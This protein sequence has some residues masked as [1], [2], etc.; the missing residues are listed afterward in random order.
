MSVE[1]RRWAVLAIWE[2]EQARQDFLETS[3][4]LRRWRNSATTLTHYSL[5]PF[6]TRGTWGGVTPFPSLIRVGQEP[7]ENIAVL[8]RA[9][10]NATKWWRFARSA[11]AVDDALRTQ[12]GCTLAMGIGEW[13]IG[14][15][16]TFSTW[17]NAEAVKAF[18]YDDSAHSE[19][20]RRT[21]KEDWYNEMLFSRFSITDVFREK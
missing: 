6:A 21:F 7:T 10:I 14:E 19:V 3:S 15:Q 11:G 9:S 16:S 12:E 2:N 17:S 5:Q 1:L 4:V 13:P 20:I 8:T 18:A